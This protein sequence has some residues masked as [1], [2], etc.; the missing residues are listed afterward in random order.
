MTRI[1]MTG[2][3]GLLGSTLGVALEARGFA[4][5][6]HARRSGDFTADLTSETATAG[7]VETIAPDCIVNLVAL[8]DVDLCESDPQQAYLANTRTVEN[9]AAAMR[10]SAGVRHL[11]HISTDQLYDGPGPHPEADVHLKNYY[12]FSK[13]TGELAAAG[14]AS[15]VLR[16]NFFGR[17][18][19]PGR[20]SFSDWLVG[21]LRRREAIRVFEDVSF[22][23][24]SLD[25]LVELACLT[26]E[27][28]VPGV[29]NVGS[30][31]GMSKADF[32]FALA[33]TL[34]LPTEGMKRGSAAEAGLRAYRPRDMRMDC[35]RF[36][37]VFGVRLPT[38]R[39][40]IESV[41]RYYRA[42]A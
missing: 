34:G 42:C 4:V 31:E 3:S 10:A 20:A 41:A 13:Y 16:T 14:V 37:R 18:L 30:H 29:F 2:A 27:R 9:L 7:L 6:R 39:Q 26:L 35:A 19:C 33:G 28:R 17:S 11:I 32:C 21:A 15:T 40:E 25:R 36:E 38:L 5:I 8:T 24:L 23:P 12:A 22:S 1:L